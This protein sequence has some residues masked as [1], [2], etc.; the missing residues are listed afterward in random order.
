MISINVTF[1]FTYTQST[2]T[3]TNVLFQS[4]PQ[5]AE[6]IGGLDKVSKCTWLYMNLWF[7]DSEE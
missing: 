1:T 2:W 4:L 6:P 3:H 7:T 5:S